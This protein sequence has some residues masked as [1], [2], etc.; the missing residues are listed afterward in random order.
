MLHPSSPSSSSQS[1][2]STTNTNTIHQAPSQPPALAPPP[3]ALP[4][5]TPQYLS[6]HPLHHYPLHIPP[7]SNPS[8]SAGPGT[9]QGLSATPTLTSNQVNSSPRAQRRY[10][11][12]ATCDCPNCQEAERLGPAGLHLRRRNIHSC[13]IPGCGKVTA[14]FK[15]PSCPGFE[16]TL[17]GRALSKLRF[18]HLPHSGVREDVTSE[19]PPPVAHWGKTFRLQLVVLREEVHP[20]GR[21]P[22]APQDAH[23]REKVSTDANYISFIIDTLRII[24]PKGAQMSA[25][26]PQRVGKMSCSC[27]PNVLF[28]CPVCNKRFMRSDHLAKHVKTHAAGGE[29]GEDDEEV[30]IPKQYTTLLITMATG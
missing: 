15:L 8:A 16:A 28:A 9:N 14:K 27:L 26:C 3:P 24:K 10:T 25:K 2:S 30:S 4:P 13:H 7:P 20:V 5:S 17:L 22:E 23:W 12:R 1:P 11:G 6:H 18:F 19:G 21:A 29:G